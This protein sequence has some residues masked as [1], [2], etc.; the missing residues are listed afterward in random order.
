LSRGGEW[1]WETCK[2]WLGCIGVKCNGHQ[3]QQQD[4]GWVFENWSG[5]GKNA[6]QQRPLLAIE[7]LEKADV[8][9]SQDME[10]TQASKEHSPAGDLPLFVFI[11]SFHITL[12]PNLDSGGLRSNLDGSLT[13]PC[14]TPMVIRPAF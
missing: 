10:R 2:V 1:H 5:C 3:E 8:G 6:S 12:M 13:Q 14:Q 11:L 7:L 9:T 4:W